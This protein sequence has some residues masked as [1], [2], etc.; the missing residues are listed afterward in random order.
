[1]RRGP[2]A[3]LAVVLGLPVAG[4]S[5]PV[6][7]QRGSKVLVREGACRSK[8]RAM[9]LSRFGALGPQG[10]TGD[11]GPGGATG[12]EGP[13]GPAGL[14]GATGDGGATGPVG[15]TG[16]DGPTGPTGVDGTTGPTGAPG[17]TGPTGATGAS[18]ATG[19]TGPVGVAIAYGRV[20]GTVAVD[21]D[22]LRA[23][24]VG[25]T[26]VIRRT[27]TAFVTPYE[28][29]FAASFFSGTPSVVVVSES[30]GPV[31]AGE[32][33]ICVVEV[34]SATGATIACSDIVVS[35]G[36]QT[37]DSTNSSFT[38]IAIGPP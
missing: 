13:T 1:M 32:D 23:G 37:P 36:G 9:D 7:C 24:A 20:D 12:P 31:H 14:Q 29:T 11:V 4:E 5:A 30:F 34:P 26:S 16:A 25:V 33:N 8:E 21:A 28:I 10:P 35:G 15:A 27:N 17:A 2:L 19:P 6:L 18:G 3:V 38:F 22:G